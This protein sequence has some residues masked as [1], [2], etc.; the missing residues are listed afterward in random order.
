M[1]EGGEP[2]W[3]EQPLPWAWS[4]SDWC[5]LHFQLFSWFSEDHRRDPW[6]SNNKHELVGCEI[7]VKRKWIEGGRERGVGSGVWGV[8]RWITCACG[9]SVFYSGRPCWIV[10]HKCSTEKASPHCESSRGECTNRAGRWRTDSTD[11]CSACRLRR[12]TESRLCSR[13]DSSDWAGTWSPPPGRGFPSTAS[14]RGSVRYAGA[15]SACGCSAPTPNCSGSAGTE[16]PAGWHE[17]PASARRCGLGTRRIRSPGTETI[18]GWRCRKPLW[19]SSTTAT[20]RSPPTLIP[21]VASIYSAG[22]WHRWP[23][24]LRRCFRRRFLVST[25]P[26]WISCWVTAYRRQSWTTH[27]LS[28]V[29]LGRLSSARSESGPHQLLRHHLRRRRLRHSLLTGNDRLYQPIKQAEKNR[30]VR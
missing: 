21:L 23:L 4:A 11:T 27:P 25:I 8:G 6:M 1:Q 19:T 28:L 29:K 12:A 20:P 9:W 15:P 22:P 2:V 18:C 14:C 5:S 17:H 24:L 3:E 26:F 16:T 7:D 13:R 30:A 10:C